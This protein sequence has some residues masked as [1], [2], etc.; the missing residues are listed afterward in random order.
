MEIILRHLYETYLHY[1]NLHIP[2]GISLKLHVKLKI[3]QFV[4]KGVNLMASF[5]TTSTNTTSSENRNHA[6][7]LNEIHRYELYLRSG[8]V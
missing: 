4:Q 5:Y 1:L 2:K 3:E 6:T 7:P 8:G